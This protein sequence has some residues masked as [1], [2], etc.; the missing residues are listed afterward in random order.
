MKNLITTLFLAG[1]LALGGCGEKNKNTELIT[2]QITQEDLFPE[3]DDNKKTEY[4]QDSCSC[5][6]EIGITKSPL[7]L[8]GTYDID[9]DGDLDCIYQESTSGRIL[10]YETHNNLHG[11]SLVGEFSKQH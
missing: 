9:K 8:I 2:S 10:L 7:K 3:K 5:M 6:P 11:Q 4:A 1:S